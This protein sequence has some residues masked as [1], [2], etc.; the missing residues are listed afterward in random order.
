MA[1]VMGS[2]FRVSN[3]SEVIHIVLVTKQ[4]LHELVL[5]GKALQKKEQPYVRKMMFCLGGT[6]D[7]QRSATVKK[8]YQTDIA[9]CRAQ[10]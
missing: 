4:L 5:A 7:S 2:G 3:L 8:A 1:L 9:V 10:S 6:K